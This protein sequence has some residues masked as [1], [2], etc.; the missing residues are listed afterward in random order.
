MDQVKVIFENEN[1]IVIDKPINFVVNRSQTTK[2][3]TLQDWI[4]SKILPNLD[5]IPDNE[6]DFKERS[7]IVHRIDK[8]TSGLLLIAKTEEYFEYLQSIF[9]TREVEKKYLVMAMGKVEEDRFEIDAPIARNP[10]NR[11]KYAIVR[12]GKESQTY[13]EKIKN[14]EIDGHEFTLLFAQPRTGRTHQIRVHLGANSSPV[15]GD[16]I[17]LSEKEQEICN[18]CKIDRLMLHSL[19]IRFKGLEEE[20]FYFESDIPDDFKKYLNQ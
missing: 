5:E 15:A 11:F 17:Y 6:S 1:F 8:D 14:I 7:G 19:S 13:F 2:D 4:E 10:N 9:K 18:S 16:K 12:D 20:E 3:S